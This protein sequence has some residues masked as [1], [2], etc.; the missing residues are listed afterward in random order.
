MLF[1]IIKKKEVIPLYML[2]LYLAFI[3]KYIALTPLSLFFFPL[4]FTFYFLF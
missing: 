4:F 1:L 2:R 3:H